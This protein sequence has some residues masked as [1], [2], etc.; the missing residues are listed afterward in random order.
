MR[1]INLRCDFNSL[2]INPS[3]TLKNN[4]VFRGK[5]INT[6]EGINTD[7]DLRF[8]IAG[9]KLGMS[10]ESIYQSNDDFVTL[11]LAYSFSSEFYDNTLAY[12]KKS[13]TTTNSETEEVSI[14]TEYLRNCQGPTYI[15]S[16]SYDLNTNDYI[17]IFS[18]SLD[19]LIG[20][21]ATV[22]FAYNN[23]K[24]AGSKEPNYLQFDLNYPVDNYE[25]CTS[26]V[27]QLEGAEEEY[28]T[29]GTAYS[30]KR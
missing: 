13:T 20:I 10:V 6:N 3:V 25:V 4:T 12:T 29:Y 30:R 22:S 17:D 7:I 24:V 11:Y 9:I 14:V 18:I 19:K 23:L 5:K 15:N 27:K 8:E 21:D 28:L 16:F 26:Y 1:N 2:P